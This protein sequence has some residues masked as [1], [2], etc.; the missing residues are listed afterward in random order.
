[1]CGGL[2]SLW[3]ELRGSINRLN[4]HKI[5]FFLHGEVDLIKLGDADMAAI[6]QQV[7]FYNRKPVKE[8][9]SLQS[10]FAPGPLSSP[11]QEI[12]RDLP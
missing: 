4:P 8:K 5:A 10:R 9:R 7:C 2:W 12:Q 11:T 1:M 6:T 3:T